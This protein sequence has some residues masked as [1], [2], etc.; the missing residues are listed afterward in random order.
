MVQYAFAAFDVDVETWKLAISTGLGALINL[1]YRWS[2]SVV[3]ER[4]EPTVVPYTGA[5]QTVNLGSQ[6][7]TAGAITGTA[8]QGVSG[9]TETTTAAMKS[10]A[11]KMTPKQSK[12][13]ST[14]ENY[15]HTY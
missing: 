8:F 12:T 9:A 11:A 6:A 1:V 2:E 3:N 13:Q 4:K 14:G 10:T 5:N 7:L 15:E